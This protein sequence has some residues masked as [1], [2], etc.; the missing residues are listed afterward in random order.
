MAQKV[1][2]GG[3]ARLWS[4]LSAASSLKPAVTLCGTGV[5]PAVFLRW[6]WI[7]EK[8]QAGRPHHKALCNCPGQPALLAPAGLTIDPDSAYCAPL[9]N[10]WDAPLAAFGEW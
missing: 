8:K 5:P 2:E 7:A 9:A 4:R 3:S 6:P 10:S 1:N